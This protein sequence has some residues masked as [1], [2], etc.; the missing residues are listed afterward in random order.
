MGRPHTHQRQLRIWWDIS[1]TEVPP[2]K[3]GVPAPPQAPEPKTPV[4]GKRTQITSEY[5]SRW[6]FHLLGWNG[7]CWKHRCL[8]KGQYTN[9]LTGTHLG[10]QPR[11]NGWLGVGR[12]IRG[13]GAWGEGECTRV[14]QGEAEVCGYRVRAG[15]TAAFVPALSPPPTW[16]NLNPHEPN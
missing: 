14:I 7:G 15:G 6:K 12:G 8:L 13:R 5:E 2:Q 1:A 11:D 9:S 4:L 3:P 10:L 16:P